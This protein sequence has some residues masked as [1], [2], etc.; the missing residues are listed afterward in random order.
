[1][2]AAILIWCQKI[3]LIISTFISLQAEIYIYSINKIWVLRW[4]L[5]LLVAFIRFSGNI[6]RY[7]NSTFYVSIIINTL[8]R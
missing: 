2:V 6:T 1:M 8:Y 4:F 5:H 7:L 3:H